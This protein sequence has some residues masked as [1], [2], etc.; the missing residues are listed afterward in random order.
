MRSYRLL[1]ASH[2]VLV[3]AGSP[4]ARSADTVEECLDQARQRAAH[5]VSVGVTD[6]AARL[7]LEVEAAR[8]HDHT[9]PAPTAR[10]IGTVNADRARFALDLLQGRMTTSEY[11]AAAEDRRRKLA[12]RRDDLAFHV[13]VLRDADRDLVPDRADR[14]PRTPFGRATND[15]GCPL[16]GPPPADDALLRRALA[17]AK[18]LYNPSCKGA[19]TPLVP[20]PIEWGRGVQ[21]IHGTSGFN[22]AVTR[23]GNTLPGCE[24]FYELQ[25]RFIAPA[26]AQLPPVAYGNVV[27]S[28]T[29]DLLAEPLRAV[30]GLPLNQPLS[31]GRTKARDALA[32]QYL[33]LTWRV[34]A[35]TGSGVASPWSAFVTQW[36]AAAGVQG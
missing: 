17:A 33:R 4:P 15:A 23:G 26:Q 36:P 14:C 24:L 20:T 9:L 16:D 28:A 6:E 8:C 3:L 12:A 13:A 2:C 1:A 19:P 7:G 11:R 27:F 21:T 32:T 31:P 18:A 25:F 34:R 22:F 35:V 10:F 5:A 30:F 29:E